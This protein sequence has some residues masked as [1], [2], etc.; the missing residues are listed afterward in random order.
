MLTDRMDSGEYISTMDNMDTTLAELGDEFT[1]GD[2]DGEL[3][4]I[5]VCVVVLC[6]GVGPFPFSLTAPRDV[7]RKQLRRS[8]L[9]GGC[10][11]HHVYC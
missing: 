9:C 10:T 4:N 11:R 5:A 6:G 2:I 8:D 3:P 7:Q 1:L